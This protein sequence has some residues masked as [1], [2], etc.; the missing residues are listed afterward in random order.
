MKYLLILGLIIGFIYLVHEFLDKN[1]IIL[2]LKFSGALFLILELLFGV[3][4]L[5]FS[6]PFFIPVTIACLIVSLFMFFIFLIIE[7]IFEIEFYLRY[8]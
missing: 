8:K 5:F 2:A 6:F 4:T 7:L 3:L 1:D